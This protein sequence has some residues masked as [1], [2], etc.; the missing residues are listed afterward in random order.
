MVAA[1][2]ARLLSDA[3]AQKKL[4]AAVDVVGR[5]CAQGLIV[6]DGDE[7]VRNIIVEDDGFGASIKA[8]SILV[9]RQ[10]GCAVVQFI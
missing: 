8:P 6:D 3:I 4:E 2:L 5:A 1:G 7:N 10:S 9:D